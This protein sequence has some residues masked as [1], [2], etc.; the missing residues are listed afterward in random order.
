MGKVSL[1]RAFRCIECGKEYP[2]TEI[3][4]SCPACAPKG[5]LRGTLDIEYDYEETKSRLSRE[6][7]EGRKTPFWKYGEL[8]PVFDESHI[9]TLGE[10]NTPL[11]KANKLASSIGAGKLHLKNET[12]NPSWSFKDRVFTVMISKALEYGRNT[13][14]LASTGNAAAA[15]SA[16]SAKAGIRCHI[17]VSETTSTAKITQML[18]HEAKVI[19]LKGGLLEAGSLAIEACKQFGWFHITTGKSM[20]PY[21]TEGPKTLAYEIAEQLN[22]EVPDNVIVPVGGGDTLGGIWKG[23]KDLKEI[24]LIDKLPHMV[25]AQAEGAP[26]VVKAF[27]ENKQFFQVMPIEPKTIAAGI[28]VGILTGPWPLNALKE[29][30]GEAE[31]VTDDEIVQSERLMA[32]KEALFAE[33]ASAAPVAVLKKLLDGGRIDKNES[34]VCIITGAGLKDIDPLEKYLVSPPT[35][36]PDIRILKSLLEQQREP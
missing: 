8:L 25:A 1:A 12:R 18:M 5:M 3:L 32:K 2:L 17:F 23:F 24:G 14:A 31:I 35:I 33:P 21:S 22:W 20:Q 11:L 9:V 13:V 29:S 26:L 16:Y 28:K 7:L 6:T 4:Y 34:S 27:R 10:G 30:D 36:K 15:A 19:K